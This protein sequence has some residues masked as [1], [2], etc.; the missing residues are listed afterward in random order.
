MH[1]VTDLIFIDPT[2]AGANPANSTSAVLF[3]FLLL[4]LFIF[5]FILFLFLSFP[6]RRSFNPQAPSSFTL[7][8]NLDHIPP[9]VQR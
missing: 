1:P 8:I 6:F 4:L 3:F 7:F 5:I 2:G 9:L